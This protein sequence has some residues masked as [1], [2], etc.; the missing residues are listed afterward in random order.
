MTNNKTPD[1]IK[2]KDHIDDMKAFIER[3]NAE[4]LVLQKILKKLIKQNE[5]LKSDHY[6]GQNK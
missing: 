5:E 2:E 3:K 4:N 1:K 6:V